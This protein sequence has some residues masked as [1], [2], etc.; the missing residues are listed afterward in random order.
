MAGGQQG[1]CSSGS[2]AHTLRRDP[3]P[4]PITPILWTPL[5]LPPRSDVYDEELFVE[6]MEV[7]HTRV[8]SQEPD[9]QQ[10]A[11]AAAGL[12]RAPGAA[13]LRMADLGDDVVEGLG[14]R[15]SQQHLR[16]VCGVC[17]VGGV[18]RRRCRARG[19]G[20]GSTRAAR[21]TPPPC[22]RPWPRNAA[23]TAP[24]FT[25]P[26]TSWPS[27]SAWRW[28]L[29]RRSSRRRGCCA[30]CGARRS[31]CAGS[32]TLGATI[33][34]T[35]ARRMIGSSTALAGPAP[36]G[37]SASGRAGV[38][39]LG[40]VGAW[41]G[42]WRAAGQAGHMPA[43]G[44]ARAHAP[45]ARLLCPPPRPLPDVVRDNCLNNTA[46]VGDQLKLHGFK[47]P[48][49]VPLPCTASRAR[50]PHTQRGGQAS[51]WQRASAPACLFPCLPPHRPS[52]VLLHV[53][54]PLLVASD[55]NQSTHRLAG[56]ALQN[57]K[58]QG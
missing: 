1:P 50:G 49:R 6:R 28:Q 56:E 22:A 3:T 33:C 32:A 48:V 38:R 27:T 20:A 14:K 17:V 11:A 52:A 35:C 53:Q 2:C 10:R 26:L 43:R 19:A 42:G 58:K 39:C 18:G 15:A 36:A 7:H 47:L 8:L 24:C 45:L 44:R 34:C 21:L 4:P 40:W 41:V 12:Q 57:L 37:V 31:S 16:C 51:P 13:R 55:W 46:T 9:A 29:C 23:S 30:R 5:S 25:P 54:V